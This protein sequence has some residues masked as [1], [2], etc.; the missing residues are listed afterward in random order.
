MRLAERYG[1]P[2]YVYDADTIRAAYRAE[3]RALAPY[4][5]ARVSYSVKACPLLGVA[6]VLAQSG[7][8]ASAAS[9]GEVLAAK[10]AGFAASR[11]QLHGNAKTVDELRGALR[12]GIGR[13]VIDG[14]DEI[15]ALSD[16]VRRRSVA[17]D[18]WLR[19]SPNIVADTHPHM[20]T[21]A[22]DSKFGA[23]IETGDALA[24]ARLIASTKGLRL[25]GVHAHIGT[26]IHEEARYRELAEKIVARISAAARIGGP[27]AAA[28]AA[29]ART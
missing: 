11:I 23:P 20:R 10:R 26:E 18:V 3:V 22:L 1:T 12:A 16:L 5:P 17:Q 4:R 14:A 15:R 19:V 7:A 9:L 21:G 2:L 6:R 25:I 8:D 29:A 28:C 24:H 27:I 13:I